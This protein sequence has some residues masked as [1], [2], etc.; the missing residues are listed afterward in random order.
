MLGWFNADAARASRRN[1]SK[2]CSVR[3]SVVGKELQGYGPIEARVFRFVHDAHA[4]ATK[5]FSHAIVGDCATH[6]GLCVRHR[7]VILDGR[8]RQVNETAHWFHGKR[9]KLAHPRP[10]KGIL[11]AM[12]V[13][14]WTLASRGRDAM[15]TT[16]R[17]TSAG[18]IVGS[19]AIVPFGWG[20]PF[21]I[22]SAM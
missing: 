7:K 18:S 3:G 11:V 20:T 10:M 17:A 2:V 12:T 6:K 21:F 15:Y 16:A 5:L 14:N 22:L 8:L 13:I 19:T 9:E 1:L 4:A